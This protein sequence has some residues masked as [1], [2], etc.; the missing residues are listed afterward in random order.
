MTAISE[1][2]T[3]SEAAPLVPCKSSET[4]RQWITVGRRCRGRVVKLRAVFVG[5][6]LT[7]AAWVEEFLAT[8][9]AG[10]VGGEAVPA[11]KPVQPGQWEREQQAAAKKLS[12]R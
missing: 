5:R 11:P 9:T 2:I 6:W 7:T 8:V 1:Y 3:L 10:R 4:L 12:R